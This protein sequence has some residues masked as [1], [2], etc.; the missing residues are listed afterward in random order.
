MKALSI[1]QPWAW[2]ILNGKPL[3]NRT[4]FT[5]YRGPFLIHTGKKFDHEGYRWIKEHAYSLF[6]LKEIPLKES[7]FLGG[8]VGRSNIINCVSNHPS[9]FFFGPYG[10]VLKDSQP[11]PFIPYPGKLG[12]FDVPDDLIKEA[13]L[14]P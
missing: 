10:F 11:I 13:P 5:P 3:E 8:F 7:F 1:Q 14:K 9:L 4:W 6:A 12:F 2:A